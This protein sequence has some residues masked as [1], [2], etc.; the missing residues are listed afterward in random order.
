MLCQSSRRATTSEKGRRR[1][2]GSCCL[3]KTYKKN[4]T[5]S[6]DVF[7]SNHLGLWVWFVVF[8]TSWYKWCVFDFTV[9]TKF[10]SQ[11]SFLKQ[12]ASAASLA[13]TRLH[14]N[15]ED[16]KSQ[17][18]NFLF[19]CALEYRW[20]QQLRGWANFQYHV[21]PYRD[22]VYYFQH[23]FVSLSRPSRN[24]DQKCP[25]QR[26][27]RC[28]SRRRQDE[29]QASFSSFPLSS[30]KGRIGFCEALSSSWQQKLMF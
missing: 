16:T 26:P 9:K 20:S 7:C 3:L 17:N 19:C 2:Q 30:L 15:S 13:Y 4:L 27:Q 8:V 22:T 28:I 6:R 24:S 21:A 5:F 23:I 14:N 1:A 11:W 10:L 12:S 18:T 29:S 25:W